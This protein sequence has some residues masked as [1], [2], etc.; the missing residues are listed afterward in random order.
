M[1]TPCF[2]LQS[3]V[4]VYLCVFTYMW[5]HV[6]GGTHTHVHKLTY[7][8]THV[9]VLAHVY[10][11]ACVLARVCTRARA[12]SLTLLIAS[13]GQRPTPTHGGSPAE[14][15][16]SWDRGPQSRRGSW[17]SR[18]GPGVPGVRETPG[19]EPVGAFHSHPS[20]SVAGHVQQDR[21]HGQSRTA[22]VGDEGLAGPCRSRRP[23]GTGFASWEDS[24]VPP[25]VPRLCLCTCAR[26]GVCTC[27]CARAG[28]GVLWGPAF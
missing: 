20:S 27:A 23:S 21:A 4:R 14:P 8:C 9:C 25:Q 3:G 18:E 12:H 22:R 16:Q 19:E 17:S 7:V 24:I 5:W 28:A 2:P 26:M 6:H 13:G 1:S 11:R 15:E 10:R